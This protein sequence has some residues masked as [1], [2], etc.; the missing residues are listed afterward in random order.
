M[1]LKVVPV[2]KKSSDTA[3]AARAAALVWGIGEGGVIWVWWGMGV[4]GCTGSSAAFR[5]SCVYVCMTC[6]C[7]ECVGLP[8]PGGCVYVL[9]PAS[10]A[11]SMS[12][13]GCPVSQLLSYS[14]Q[15]SISVY[16]EKHHKQ[17]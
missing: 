16:D 14:A 4:S 10:W 7:V 6:G 17:Y 15:L 8:S 5:A 9:V 3:G 11:A 12:A 1:I 2:K 13:G